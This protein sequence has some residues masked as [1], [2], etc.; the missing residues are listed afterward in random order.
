V[1]RIG[2]TGDVFACSIFPVPAG[3][4]REASFADIWNGSPVLRTIRGINLGDLQE[5]CGGC[6]RQSYCGRCSAQALL[7]HGNFA[8]PSADACDRAEARERAAGLP[9]PADA[10]RMG[11]RSRLG[12]RAIDFVPLHTLVRNAQS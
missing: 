12:R 5:E 9:P 2:P 1:V 8:G 4:L 11:V 3:N 7:E 6:S 10:H